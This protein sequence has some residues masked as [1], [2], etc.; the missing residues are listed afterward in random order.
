MDGNDLHCFEL[1]MQTTKAR[2][3]YL[4]ALNTSI[5]RNQW[6]QKLIEVMTNFFP[7]KHIVDFTRAGWCFIKVRKNM[8]FPYRKYML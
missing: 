8:P 2:L 5:E 1:N 7:A 4:F 6:A 3:S